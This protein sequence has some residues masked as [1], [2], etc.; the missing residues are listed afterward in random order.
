MAKNPKSYTEE[1]RREAARLMKTSG[2]PVGAVLAAH[3]Q[4]KTV[5]FPPASP[6]LN[7][8]EHVWSLARA[9]ISHNHM[10]PDYP[11][12]GMHSY[13]ISLPICF[14]LT[15]SVNMPRLYCAIAKSFIHKPL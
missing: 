9:N 11:P 2:K 5:F 6:D 12:C 13:A 10:L 4:V 3:P 14:A 7:P 15:G 1:F 8:Q